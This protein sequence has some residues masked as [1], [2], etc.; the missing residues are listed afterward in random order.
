MPYNSGGPG[1]PSATV[2]ISTALAGPPAELTATPGDGS[3]KLSFYSPGATTFQVFTSA[4]NASFTSLGY[5]NG[6]APFTQTGLTNGATYYYYAVPYNGN[7]AGTRSS[8]VSA[9][10]SLPAPT[11]VTASQTGGSVAVAWGA[12]AAPGATDYEVFASTDGVHFSSAGFT[13]GAATFVQN[14]LNAASP[15]Y[16]YVVPIN[17]GGPGTPSSAVQAVVRPG[18]PTNVAATPGDG[19][20]KVSWDPALGATNYEVFA[21]TDNVTFTNLG[22]TSGATTFTQPG[23]ANGTMHYYYVVA[24]SSGNA[25]PNSATVSALVSLPAPTNG[26]AN[27]ANGQLTLNW[28]ASGYPGATN[29]QV[30]YTP[31]NVSAVSLG[32]TGG[33]PTLT[34][35]NLSNATTYYYWVVPYNNGGKGAAGAEFQTTTGFGPPTNVTATPGSGSVTVHWSFVSG[36]GGYQVYYSS[37]NVH[38]SSTGGGFGT[39]SYTQTGLT[40]GTRYY[41]YVVSIGSSTTSPPSATVSA[42]PL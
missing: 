3:V 40:S 15:Y 37:D 32:Y 16:F 11:N 41:F 20:V 13:G 17:S 1:T 24:Y 18:P 35:N 25:S 29:Y 14:N 2:F 31:N 28:T 38:F 6:T 5:T 9:K 36:A 7:T 8:T 4:D 33:A 42:V 27:Y 22:D 12:S 26:T 34:V 39:N 19:Q 21:S 10:V 30:F 23:L